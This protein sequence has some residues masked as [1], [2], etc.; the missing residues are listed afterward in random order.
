MKYFLGLVIIAISLVSPHTARAEEN[1]S[2]TDF[3][4]AI[5]ITDTGA[6]D[7]EETI[8]VDFGHEVKH[9]IYRYIPY[10]YTSADKTKTYTR[11]DLNSV[12]MDH[13][14][15]RYDSSTDHDRLFI[16]IG[17]PKKTLSGQHSYQ[18]HYSATGILR[19]F[20]SYD[21]LYWNVTGND[22]PVTIAKA[23]AMVTLP[24]AGIVQSSCYMGLVGATN[25]CSHGASDEQH[26][27][28][29][30]TSP[31]P[32]YEGLTIALGYTKGMVPLTVVTPPP[33]PFSLATS[34]RSLSAAGI[35]SLMGLALVISLWW[36]LGRDQR[37]QR[38]SANPSGSET[39]IMPLATHETIAPEF[40]SPEK[41]RPAEI[42][43]LMDER[44]DTLDVSATI[45]DLAVRGYLT[46]R[47]E[48]KKWL[49]GATDYT[50]A[51]T[52]KNPNNLL[53]YEKKLLEALFAS[54]DTILL[55]SLK[56]HFYDDLA[57]VKDSLY[58]DVTEKKLFAANPASVRIKYLAIGIVVVVVGGGLGVLGF[59]IGMPEFIGAGG[60]LII[61]GLVLLA[62]S[63]AMPRRTA[64]GRETWRRAQGYKLFVSGTEKYRQPFFEKENIF[65]EVLPY[66]IVFGVTKKLAQAMKDLGLKPPQP[67]WYYGPHPFNA[68]AFSNNLDSFSHAIG[69]AMA[70]SPSGSGSSGGG[71]SGGGFGGGGGGSW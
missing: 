52:A 13:E 44:A 29:A 41:L 28:F 64:Y 45:V 68:Y 20:A 15:I 49:L 57:Q 55:S 22:W 9:G 16:K 14:A 27:Q 47:E 42:G 65:M 40:E 17:D 69:T 24:R 7:V 36:R 66:A 54:G 60:G 59:R 58:K 34:S 62:V 11:L 2:I 30:T 50:F 5:T 32:P 43:V 19:G 35:I 51:K 56:N 8:A 39:A 38:P 46:I 70:S 33:S 31:L 26:A 3:S 21:E 61:S 63:F 4:S 18:I 67:T 37:W 48:S 71:F 53:D 10:V 23:S 25:T 6:I 1:W 12:T